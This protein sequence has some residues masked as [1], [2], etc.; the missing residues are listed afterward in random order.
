VRTFLA[1]VRVALAVVAFGG[2]LARSD[3][4]RKVALRPHGTATHG[5]RGVVTDA[6]LACVAIGIVLFVAAYQRFR[7]TRAE[8]GREGAGSTQ[9]SAMESL[10]AVSL[11]AIGIAFL[12][13]LAG[14]SVT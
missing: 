5:P 11:A 4:F 8:I 2:I 13:V 10:L 6:G 12:A 1:W 9:G 3:L 14:V 7:R